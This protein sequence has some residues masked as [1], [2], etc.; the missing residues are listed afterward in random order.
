MLQREFMHKRANVA[1]KAYACLG[2]APEA[3]HYLEKALAAREPNLAELLQDPYITWMH[4]DDQFAT[5][6]R[7][8]KLP[9]RSLSSPAH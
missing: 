7:E 1:A 4:A 8:L 5:F 6:R 3:V 2:N 9:D